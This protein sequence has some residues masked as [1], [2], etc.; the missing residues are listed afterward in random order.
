M[1]EWA[2]QCGTS[3]DRLPERAH[4]QPRLGGVEVTI[5]ILLADDH[6]LF[7]QGLRSLIEEQ[8]DFEVVGEARDGRE[9]LRLAS[10]KSPHVVLLDIAMPHMNGLEAARQ[11]TAQD[12]A[13]KVV[14]LSMHADPRYVREMVRAGASGYLLKD[15][16]AEEVIAAIR[17]VMR[18]S[19]FLS[20]EIAQVLLQD[21]RSSDQ[22]GAGDDAC[23]LSR[24]EREVLQL[25]AEGNNSKQIA[26]ALGISTKTVENHR[27]SIMQQLDLRTVAELTKYAVRHGIT[28]ID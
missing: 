11:L 13:T 6:K 8:P 18:G 15:S 27:R 23:G 2:G 9:A 21:Y 26:A 12:H 7:R 14:A 5:R 10:E 3:R 4:A 24:R 20:P 22:P 19:S 25:L 28:S 16:A 17:C 1:T